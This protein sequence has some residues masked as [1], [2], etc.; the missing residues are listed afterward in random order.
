MSNVLSAPWKQTA[1]QAAAAHETIQKAPAQGQKP[2]VGVFT[3][4][5]SGDR[6]DLYQQSFERASLPEFLSSVP[7]R[8]LNAEMIN[9]S[10]SRGLSR[11]LN[12]GMSNIII[13]LFR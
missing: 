11:F 3:L 13:L 8:Q 7:L 12:G 1:R 9:Q 4:I 2:V 6:S 10:A 5:E